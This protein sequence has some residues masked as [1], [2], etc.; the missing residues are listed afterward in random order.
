MWGVPWSDLPLIAWYVLTL[1]VLEGLLSADNALVLAVMVRHLPRKQQKRALRYGLWGAFGFRLIAVLLSAVLMRFWIFKVIGGLY[2]VY[3]A[4]AHFLGAHGSSAGEHGMDAS[5][6]IDTWRK[7]FWGTVVSVELADVAFS[8]D[9]ILAAV[10]M[11]E[12]L[13]ERYGDNWKLAIVYIGGVLG[14]I[15]MRYVAGYFIVLLDRFG[16]LATAA[17]LLVAWIGLKLVVGGLHSGGKLDA[18]IPGWLLWSV[19]LGIAAIGPLLP[20]KEVEP[21]GHGRGPGEE[22]SSDG[23]AAEHE[24]RPARLR[25]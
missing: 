11:A 6:K 9:S 10:G 2:L 22:P 7:S 20:S 4:L 17:Y 19:M 8:I 23:P 12:S 18:E 1:V 3:L 25:P 21:A 5:G 13:P 15:T 14:I 24:D 16:G